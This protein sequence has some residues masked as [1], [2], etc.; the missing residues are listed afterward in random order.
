ML[1]AVGAGGDRNACTP[2]VNPIPLEHVHLPWRV[3]VHRL[4]PSWWADCIR[5][6]S[7]L[8]RSSGGQDAVGQELASCQATRT[9]VRNAGAFSCS[10]VISRAF[11]DGAVPGPQSGTPRAS[12]CSSWL[13]VEMVV[14][15]VAPSPKRCALCR[16][17]QVSPSLV[18]DTPRAL[19]VLS[20][21][22]AAEGRTGGVE[23]MRTKLS[24]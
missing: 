11:L 22:G 21:A 14:Q 1:S 10:E 3:L 19:E 17:C 4:S 24:V 23:G 12:S 16:Q 6:S 9:C 2:L 20:A 13:P 15:L 8:H 5:R 7:P 18:G